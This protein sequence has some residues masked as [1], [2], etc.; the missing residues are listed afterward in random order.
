MAPHAHKQ[1]LSFDPV[2]DT[3]EWR[4]AQMQRMV[5]GARR[6]EA[7]AGPVSAEEAQAAQARVDAMFER[8]DAIEAQFARDG[9]DE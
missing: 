1:P 7:E 5:E 2:I 3:S 9:V 8:L 4:R 6:L